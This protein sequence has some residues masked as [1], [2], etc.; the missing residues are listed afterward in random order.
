MG[1]HIDLGATALPAIGRDHALTRTDLGRDTH[2]AK[3]GMVF[4]VEAG[5]AEGVGHYCVL[6]MRAFLGLMRMETLVIAP[7]RVDA[8]LLNLDWVGAFGTETLMAEFYD[9]QLTPLPAACT[10]E[11]ERAHAAGADLP[12]APAAEERW[13]SPI[14][15]PFSCRKRGRGLSGR[16]NGLAQDYLAS[17]LAVLSAAEPC[18]VC[19]KGEKVRDFARR[20]LDEGGPA[21]D[22]VRKS[23]GNDVAE[24]LVM[25]HMYGVG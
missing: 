3:R 20:L 21:V 10:E 6:R 11:L 25:R 14:L 24:R 15:Y 13:R 7:T 4:D 19:E 2:L 9:D 1:K 22:F 23:F 16:F 18:D 12:D 5:E 8:P 17:Y